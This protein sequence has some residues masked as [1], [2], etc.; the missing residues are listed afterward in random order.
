MARGPINQH[1]DKKGNFFFFQCKA[2]PIENIMKY[3][4]SIL[5]DVLVKY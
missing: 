3:N 1:D 2:M 5:Y 4:N